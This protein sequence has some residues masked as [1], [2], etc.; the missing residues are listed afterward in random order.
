MDGITLALIG[1]ILATLLSGIG[2]A[3]GVKITASAASGVLAEKPDLF[4]R[5]LI[6]VA[7]PSTNGIY[8]FLISILILVQT[9]II[10]GGAVDV[11]KADG[12]KYLIASIPIAVVGLLAAIYQAKAAASAIY[13]AGKK[14]ELSARGIV[15]SSLIETYPILS[16]LISVLI[17]F[18]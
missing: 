12:I 8:G 4:G 16:L 11:S 3:I 9:G 15:M 7:I 18:G 13:M 17:I 10:S 6:L 2:S 14:P 1:A 5:L